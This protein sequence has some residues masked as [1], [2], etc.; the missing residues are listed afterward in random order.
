MVFLP[1]FGLNLD[2]FAERLA[3]FGAIGMLGIHALLIKAVYSV[4]PALNFVAIAAIAI[5]EIF[6][7]AFPLLAIRRRLDAHPRGFPPDR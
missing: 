3:Q 5:A 4:L 2:L 6:I 7:L 1:L